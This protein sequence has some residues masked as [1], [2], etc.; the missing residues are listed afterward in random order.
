MKIVTEFV[1]PPIPS[2]DMDWSAI[3]Q[4]AYDGAEDAHPRNQII[5]RGATEQAAIDDLMAQLEEFDD[6]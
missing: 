2:R 1:Y 5:G 4:D 6:D 3:D